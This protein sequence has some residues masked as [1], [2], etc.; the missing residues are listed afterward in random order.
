METNILETVTT[1]EYTINKAIS[2]D[3]VEAFY[4]S[5]VVLFD[6][7]KRSII[8]QDLFS[9]P[10][11]NLKANIEKGSLY[12]LKKSNISLG[13]LTF[14]ESE[15]EEFKEIAWENP[16]NSSLYI[17][18]IFVL[19]FWRNRG[20]GSLLLN[21][22]EELAREKGY[23]TIRLD[24]TSNFDDGNLLLMKHNY[25]FAGNIYYKFQK[26]PINCYEKSI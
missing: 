13:M 8:H 15:P 1:Q 26:T 7:V 23:K 17:S 14:D 21:F 3:V 12:I 5:K 18:R 9:Q 11:Q 2:S 20:I 22:A 25:R 19:P 4:I 24:T 6:L 10:Y 16:A